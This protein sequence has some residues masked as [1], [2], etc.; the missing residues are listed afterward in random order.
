VIAIAGTKVNLLHQSHERLE[1]DLN[2]LAGV[3]LPS[4]TIQKYD[5]VNDAHDEPSIKLAGRVFD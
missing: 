2:L 4:L 3:G 5:Q 1:K